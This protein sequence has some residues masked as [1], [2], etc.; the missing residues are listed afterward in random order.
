MFG[1]ARF[2]L[3]GNA[4]VIG[5]VTVGKQVGIWFGAVVGGQGGS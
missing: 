5:D 2:L 4:T 1:L 3:P